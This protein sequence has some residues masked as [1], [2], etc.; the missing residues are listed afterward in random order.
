M[1]VGKIDKELQDRRFVLANLAVDE[2][3]ITCP[4]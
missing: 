1:G 4:T 2:G 3:K